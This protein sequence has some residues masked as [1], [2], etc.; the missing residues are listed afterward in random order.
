MPMTTYVVTIVEAGPYGLAAAAHL[1][2]VRGLDVGVF[3]EPMSFWERH[4]PSCMLFR[5]NWSGMHIAAPKSS[6]TV[7]GRPRRAT[8]GHPCGASVAT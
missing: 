2:T 7:N 3:G 5:S 6:L 8:P 4:M 1:G